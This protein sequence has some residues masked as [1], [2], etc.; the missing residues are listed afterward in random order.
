VNVYR[1]LDGLLCERCALDMVD[2]LKAKGMKPP[3]KPHDPYEWVVGP[4]PN[5]GGEDDRPQYCDRCGIFLGNPLTLEGELYVL[6]MAR[7]GRQIP[8]EWREQYSY[9]FKE[10]AYKLLDWLEQ[11]LKNYKGC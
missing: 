3:Q 6:S 7:R 2:M 4:F 10:E 8:S 1:F 11:E 5:G 9:L